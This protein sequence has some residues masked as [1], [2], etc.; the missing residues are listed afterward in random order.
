MFQY[1]LYKTETAGVYQAISQPLE[2]MISLKV[3]VNGLM[4][5][6]T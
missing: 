2:Y 3:I 4:P 6:F 5:M 1:T